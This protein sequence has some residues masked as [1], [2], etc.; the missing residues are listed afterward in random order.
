MRRTII[1]IKQDV[2]IGKGII[3][4]KGDVIEVIRE[5]ETGVYGKDKEYQYPEEGHDLTDETGRDNLANIKGDP[6]EG[7]T[8]EGD[9]KQEAARRRKEMQGDGNPSEVNGRDMGV[10]RPS[11]GDPKDPDEER[12]EV[13]VDK[14]LVPNYANPENN[15]ETLNK[16][17]GNDDSAAKAKAATEFTKNG[18]LAGQGVSKDQVNDQAAKDKARAEFMKNGENKMP[19]ITDSTG[20]DNNRL[21]QD[22]KKERFYNRRLVLQ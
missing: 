20:R 15:G 9:K 3:L 22:M 16:G 21:A 8:L 12:I 6:Y 17:G 4:E 10:D 11:E 13:S 7:K 19:D 18:D 14:T 2:A 1:E 5:D